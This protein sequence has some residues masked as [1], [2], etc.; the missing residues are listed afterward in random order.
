M[1]EEPCGGLFPP[2][3]LLWLLMLPWLRLLLPVLPLM[4]LSRTGLRGSMGGTAAVPCAFRKPPP[5]PRPCS[6]GFTA[7]RNVCLC[8]CAVCTMCMWC[9]VIVPCVWPDRQFACKDGHTAVVHRLLEAGAAVE[10]RT[11]E[12]ATALYIAARWDARCP[13]WA[14]WE[15]A[16]IVWGG[17]WRCQVE[18]GFARGYTRRR[19]M[20]ER[21]NTGGRDGGVGLLETS[22]GGGGLVLAV[23]RTNAIVCVSFLTRS[24]R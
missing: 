24:R 18:G 4:L 7:R 13:C 1:Q 12:G 14:R 19:V 9:C 10:E 15:A 22:V 6:G 2:L 20:C 21:E 11:K 3:L 23:S 5:P 16:V 17:V 8:L